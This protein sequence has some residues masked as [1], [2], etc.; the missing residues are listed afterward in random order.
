MKQQTLLILQMAYLGNKTI[1]SR[2][3]SG[4]QY[5]VVLFGILFNFSVLNYHHYCLQSPKKVFL[6]WAGFNLGPMMA[7]VYRGEMF[8]LHVASSDI[9]WNLHEA[10]FYL[11]AFASFLTIVLSSGVLFYILFALGTFRLFRKLFCDV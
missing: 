7:F 11:Q 1:W 10:V 2:N 4:E 5:L 8:F 9:L 6:I 3:L